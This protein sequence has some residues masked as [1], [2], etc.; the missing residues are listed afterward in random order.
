M[1]CPGAIPPGPAGQTRCARWPQCPRRSCLGDK[2]HVR[3]QMALQTLRPS[4]QGTKEA[5]FTK[6]NWIPPPRAIHSW[7]RR[8]GELW[9]DDWL[10]CGPKVSQELGRAA[11]VLSNQR[12]F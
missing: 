6:R 11:R 8:Q 9:E 2:C 10:L 12:S 3:A 5:P 1:D 4:L 7:T